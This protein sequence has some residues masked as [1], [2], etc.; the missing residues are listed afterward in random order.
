[1]PR[2]HPPLRS[3]SPLVMAP[4]PQPCLQP[5]S[6]TPALSA[7]CLHSTGSLWHPKLP[8]SSLLAWLALRP[9]LRCCFSMGPSGVK[10]GSFPLCLCRAH[11]QRSFQHL[12]PSLATSCFHLEPVSSPRACLLHHDRSPCMEILSKKTSEGKDTSRIL[13]LTM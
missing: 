13:K 11:T 10:V 4:N 12:L 6:P 3:R 2:E 1:M 9:E 7:T 5:N 8:H